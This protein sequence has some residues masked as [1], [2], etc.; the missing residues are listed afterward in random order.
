[1]HPEANSSSCLG[2]AEP[3]AWTSKIRDEGNSQDRSLCVPI[4]L[5]SHH[6]ND[7]IIADIVLELFKPFLD[8]VEAFSVRN[9]VQEDTDV[10]A[11]IIERSHRP[12]SFLS[13]GIPYL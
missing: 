12:E 4:R 7:G 1:M 13:G 2:G 8:V 3:S 6:V 5:G 11:S 9:I 10:S